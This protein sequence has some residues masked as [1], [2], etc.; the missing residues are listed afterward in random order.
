MNV[1]ELKEILE[2]VDDDTHVAF[3]DND[4]GFYILDKNNKTED[5][6]FYDLIHKNGSGD[7]YEEYDSEENF[8]INSKSERYTSKYKIEE[9]RKGKAIIFEVI[10]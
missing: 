9:K 2:N 7:S 10:I 6:V 4:E 3:L 5:I 8:L 1:K